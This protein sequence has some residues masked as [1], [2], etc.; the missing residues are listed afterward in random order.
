MVAPVHI[1]SSAGVPL[2]DRHPHWH[3]L[4]SDLMR[5]AAEGSRKP[6]HFCKNLDEVPFRAPAGHLLSL[7]NCLFRSHAYLLVELFVFLWL[8]SLWIR[9]INTLSRNW[10]VNIFSPFS[11][12][13][14]CFVF[15]L[16]CR[17][18]FV[19]LAVYL[20]WLLEP[21]LSG[22]EAQKRCQCWCLEASLCFLLGFL[23]FQAWYLNLLSISS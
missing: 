22:R 7:E 12:L 16:R 8:G 1:P 17:S 14:F 13:L 5:T 20:F 11:K 21:E 9:D 10:I 6:M 4:S 15:L 3:L 2:P 23:W 18:C 19:W